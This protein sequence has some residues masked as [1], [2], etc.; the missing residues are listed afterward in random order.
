MGFHQL[1]G[2]RQTESDPVGLVV[3]NGVNSR[4]R[5]AAGTPAP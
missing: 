1:T 4:G 5:T 3:Q 2:E